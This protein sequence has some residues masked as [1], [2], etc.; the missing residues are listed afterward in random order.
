MEGPMTNE[1]TDEMKAPKWLQ[2][3]K[4][5]TQLGRE[6]PGRYRGLRRIAE[7][8]LELVEA[9]TE[10]RRAVRVRKSPSAA[11][12]KA[13]RVCEIYNARLVTPGEV[14]GV[15]LGLRFWSGLYGHAGAVFKLA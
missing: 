11:C 1:N 12:A 6:G 2:V 14:E 5:A 15:T 13:E 4:L 8:A 3:T 10:A 9:G 7:D